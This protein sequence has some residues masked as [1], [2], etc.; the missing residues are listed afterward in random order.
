MEL[1][2]EGKK[3]IEQEKKSIPAC[4]FTFCKSG[5]IGSDTSMLELTKML[6]IQLLDHGCATYI[7]F[8]SKTFLQNS[9]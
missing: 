5:K 1:N 3:E 4:R 9:Q 8:L 6:K 7:M 2:R